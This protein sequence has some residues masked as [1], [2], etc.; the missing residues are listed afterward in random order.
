MIGVVGALLPQASAKAGT[1]FSGKSLQ[2]WSC[3][4]LAEAFMAANS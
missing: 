1:T 3:G 2:V 4:G